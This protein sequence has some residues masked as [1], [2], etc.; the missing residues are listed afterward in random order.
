MTKANQ[1]RVGETVNYGFNG[2]YYTATVVEVSAS[3]HQIRVQEKDLGMKLFTR[4]ANG[5]YR[6]AGHGT[7]TLAH[8]ERDE[9]N[10]CF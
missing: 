5:S 6:S 8:G 1:Y 9:R 2:D 4:R 7:W 3:G 10:P